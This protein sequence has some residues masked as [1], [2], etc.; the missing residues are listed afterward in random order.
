VDD[1]AVAPLNLPVGPAVMG[2]DLSLSATGVA[3]PNGMVGTIRTAA[4]PSIEDRLL[5]IR[6]RIATKVITASPDLIVIEA[7]FVGSRQTNVT[8][9][10][11]ML[12]GTIR[13]WLRQEGWRFVTIPP[14]T[15]KVFATG[16]GAAKKPDMRMELFK[17]TGLDIKDDNQVDAWWLRAMGHQACGAALVD[18]PQTHL[19]ALVKI[20][21]PST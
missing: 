11:G 16:S 8:F 17:R 9:D 14:A 18:L 1:E 12:H 4:Q 15:L 10:L 7:A 3:L 19:R 2:L 20:A 21:W 5:E 6:H 13:T